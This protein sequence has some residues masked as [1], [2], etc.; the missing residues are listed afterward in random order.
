MAKKATTPVKTVEAAKAAETTVKAEAAKTTAKVE[1][2]ETAEK[3]TVKKETAKKVPA[4]KAAAKKD[5]KV[6]TYIQ[7]MGREVEEKTMIAAVKKAWTKSGRK[8]GEIKSMDLYIK[9]EESAVYYVINGI[10]TGSVG[11]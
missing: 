7:Y 9:P 2:K 4:K 10:D 3:E 5:V 8:V 1:K 6:N 11:F